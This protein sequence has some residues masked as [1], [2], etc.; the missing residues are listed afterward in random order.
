MA[1]AWDLPQAVAIARGVAIRS[2]VGESAG[3]KAGQG[4]F[5][6]CVD[7]DD[8]HVARLHLVPGISSGQ[9]PG[10][11]QA[12]VD[13]ARPGC[14]SRNVAVIYRSSARHPLEGVEHVRLSEREASVL[15]ETRFEYSLDLDAVS[16]AS[17]PVGLEQCSYLRRDV[18]RYAVIDRAVHAPREGCVAGRI[19]LLE[20]R[21]RPVPRGPAHEDVAVAHE[22]RPRAVPDGRDVVASGRI[23]RLDHDSATELPRVPRELCE[24][25]GRI[26]NIAARQRLAARRAGRD[27]LDACP[28]VL[29]QIAL[30]GGEVLALLVAVRTSR[31]RAE[32]VSDERK[33]PRGR[34]NQ[35]TNGRWRHGER[36]HIRGDLSSGRG[37]A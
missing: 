14:P 21:K 31:L 27:D 23:E 33:N 26:P 22:V 19:P 18:E 37:P 13:V 32:P 6:F 9:G 29:V 28:R 20:R 35:A 34:W 16:R 2:P 36:G 7:L 25:P 15:G 17:G 11:C 4:L 12:E 24:H 3:E 10:G 30:S 8:R 1:R 5:G